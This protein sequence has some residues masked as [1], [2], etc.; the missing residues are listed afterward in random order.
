MKKLILLLLALNFLVHTAWSAPTV[1]Q[2]AITNDTHFMRLGDQLIGYGKAKW[3]SEKY[4]IPFYLSK[5][6]YSD[7]LALSKFEKKVSQKIKWKKVTIRDEDK[8][9]SYLKNAKPNEKQPTLF[10][11][12]IVTRI[13][14]STNFMDELYLT[15]CQNEPFQEKL[16]KAFQPLVPVERINLPNDMITVAV[17]VRKGSG[18][19]ALPGAEQYFDD[20]G[21]SVDYDIIDP[22][23][24]NT[25]SK[26]T[27]VPLNS[28]I[29]FKN[30]KTDGIDKIHPNK[31]PPEQYYVN[32]LKKL[33]ELLHD[34][35]LFAYIFT[36]D[37]M[38]QELIQR[39]EKAVNKKN[40]VF[41]TREK[42]NNYVEHIFDDIC[43]MAQFDCLI[44]AFS[45]FSFLSQFL[46]THKIIF[47]PWHS[48]WITEK[49]FYIDKVNI[50][51]NI[52]DADYP[53]KEIFDLM[54]SP[55][56]RQNTLSI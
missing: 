48:T 6:E 46:G 41:A 20:R 39:F 15:A 25:C 38:P 37:P 43:M 42:E 50:F 18:G 9:I 13:S 4:K 49:R 21:L 22:K 10:L 7:Q 40:I 11:I 29:F 32:Q 53:Y 56:T 5:F 54:L 8:L 16:K 2:Y 52:P 36:D 28:I 44:R 24:I 45:G 55:T 30:K 51:I 19:E 17:H 1:P 34:A 14:K 47:A 27:N 3:L 33:S 31:F 26:L 23:N 12:G 35:P